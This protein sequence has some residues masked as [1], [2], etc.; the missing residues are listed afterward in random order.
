MNMNDL[1]L[2]QH[3]KD[4]GMEDWF[5]TLYGKTD[6][7]RTPRDK[8]TKAEIQHRKRRKAKGKIIKASRKRNRR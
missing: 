4:L 8:P 2:R 3:A 7:A 6:E 1:G 5:D